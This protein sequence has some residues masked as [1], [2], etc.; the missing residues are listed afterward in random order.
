MKKLLKLSALAT[1]VALALVACKSDDD[2]EKGKLAVA[3]TDAPVDG[4]EAVVVQFTGVEIQGPGGPQSFDFNSP[5]TIDLLEL[6]GDE[7][8]ELLAETELTYGPSTVKL[9]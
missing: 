3:V 1:S 2:P 7:S 4:A 8:L 9:L 5:K 6:T